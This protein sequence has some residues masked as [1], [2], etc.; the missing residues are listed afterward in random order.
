LKERLSFLL[1]RIGERLWVKPLIMC[2]VSIVVVFGA[3]MADRSGLGDRV[4]E[5][6]VDLLEKLLTIMSSSMLV[7]ATFAVSSMVASYASASST[8]TPRSFS[9]VLADDVSQN[10]L[11]TFIG[12]FI[13]SIVALV[14][15]KSGYFASP[16][17]FALFLLTL[18][19]LA[20]VILTFVNWVDRIAR[21]GRLGATID[22]VEAAAT[23]SL[24]K[25]RRAPTQGCA[26]AGSAHPQGTPVVGHRVGYLQRIDAATLE[27]VAAAAGVTVRVAALPGSFVTPDRPI[28]YVAGEDTPVD[29]VD[30]D[31]LRSGFVIGDDR[32]FDEDPRFGLIVLAEIAS[33]A[34]SPAVNDAGTAIDVIGTFVRLFALWSE[35]VEEEELAPIECE[36]VLMPTVCADDM[37]DDAF[38]AIARDG[39]GAIEVASRLQKAFRTLASIGDG[40]MQRAAERH[41]RHALSR[42]ERALDLPEEIEI[43]RSLSGI[44]SAGVGPP[45][46]RKR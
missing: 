7:I 22:K 24:T 44:G 34:L 9:L 1:N 2:V 6:T 12:A 38:T 32:T 36:H 26:P 10:A 39:A 3:K 8:A 19:V 45:D 33:R 35:P 31:R 16:G 27:T 11:S 29:E 18:T 25:R 23:A 14:V 41:A 15:L 17:R 5:I 40:P 4:P 43:L 30:M 37:F 42:A 20:S 13:F 28:A 46:S 21:L